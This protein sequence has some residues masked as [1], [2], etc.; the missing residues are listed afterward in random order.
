V[1]SLMKSLMF[2]VIGFALGAFSMKQMAEKETLSD[3]GFKPIA[4]EKSVNQSVTSPVTQS[5]PNNGFTPIQK[6]ETNSGFKPI[7]SSSREQALLQEN[8]QLKQ[9][10]QY[11]ENQL[12]R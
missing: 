3:T 10:V 6:Q 11:L 9:R 5:K 12:R 1:N 4:M 2:L 7:Q 8:Q